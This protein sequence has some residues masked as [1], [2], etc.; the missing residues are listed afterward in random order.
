MAITFPYDLLA[1]FPGWQRGPMTV[2]RRQERSRSAFGKTYVKDLGDPIWRVEYFTKPLKPNALETWRARLDVLDEGLNTFKAYNIPRC[3][4]IAYPNGSWP[5]G[6]AFSGVGA[7]SEIAVNRKEIRVSGF[8]IG[9]KFSIGD[10]IMIT[11]GRCH[12]V[13]NEVTVSST[14]TSPF[15]EVRPHLRIGLAVGNPATVK[16]PWVLM[17]VDPETADSAAGLNGSG[18]VSFSA[19]EAI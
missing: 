16:R 11:D 10:F 5:T 13:V 4:P 15:I 12:R 8:P 3:Y 2:Y 7:I 18:A 17:Q 19:T 1:G 9:Y 6:G 14:T